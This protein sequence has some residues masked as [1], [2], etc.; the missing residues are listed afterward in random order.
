TAEERKRAGGAGVYY[1]LDYHGGPRSYQWINTSPL[2]KIWDQMSL[3]KQYGADRIWIVNVGHL[4]GYELPLE[5]FMDLAWE[6]SRWTST[7]SPN[8]PGCGPPANSAP[9]MP[10]RSPICSG[11]T[12]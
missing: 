5:Y 1:H 2:P 3:A 11:S 7:N 12:P 9:P 4:K 8:T 10:P 6:T